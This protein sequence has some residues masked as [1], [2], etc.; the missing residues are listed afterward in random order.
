MLPNATVFHFLYSRTSSAY[1]EPALIESGDSRLTFEGH[2]WEAGQSGNVGF[3]VINYGGP[4]KG[5]DVILQA[6]VWAAPF[7]SVESAEIRRYTK[8]GQQSQELVFKKIGSRFL[9]RLE[10]FDIL[11]GRNEM[12]A[13]WCRTRTKYLCAEFNIDLKLRSRAPLQT[14]L[15]LS[16]NPFSGE[17]CMTTI[18]L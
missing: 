1:E 4:T 5:L 7:L 9:C 15:S 12:S 16:V 8:Q 18:T 11:P 14:Q 3:S 10:Q 6:P 17:G 2:G 13:L